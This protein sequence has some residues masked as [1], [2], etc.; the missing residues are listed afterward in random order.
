MY[1]VESTPFFPQYIPSSS[2]IYCTSIP[3]RFPKQE[4]SL[5]LDSISSMTTSLDGTHLATGSSRGQ[6]R[7]WR[8]AFDLTVNRQ[9]FLGHCGGESISSVAFTHDSL[10]LVSAAAAILVWDYLAI[11]H[12]NSS[13]LAVLTYVVS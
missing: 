13:L 12:V 10:S 4:N 6:L 5:H 9:T 7:V 1:I 3:V 8:Y 11:P 2:R